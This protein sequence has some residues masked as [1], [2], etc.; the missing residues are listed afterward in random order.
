MTVGICA[1]LSALR[2]EYRSSACRRHVYSS[3][4]NYCIPL[5]LAIYYYCRHRWRSPRCL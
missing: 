5:L 3:R 1:H 2:E 4:K